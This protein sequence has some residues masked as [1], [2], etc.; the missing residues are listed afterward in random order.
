MKLAR[1]FELFLCV[2]L[3]LAFYGC[4]GSD[5]DPNMDMDMDMDMDGG[6]DS[7]TPFVPPS[8]GE[9]VK[10]EPEGAVCANGSQYKYFVNFAD[11]GEGNASENF[12]FYF[13]PGGACWDYESCTQDREIRGAANTRDCVGEP[14]TVDCLPD[15]HASRWFSIEVPPESVDLAEDFGIV[16]GK[17]PVSLAFPLLSDNATANP[18]HDWNKVWVSYCTGDV[19]SGNKVV[20]YANPDDS[21]RDGRVSPR[22]QQQHEAN[23][24]RTHFKVSFSRKDDGHRV[25]CWRYGRIVQL[26]LS[27]QRS[28]S[29]ARLSIG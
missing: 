16:D 22:G 7:G 13:E 14:S 3:S 17:A 19:H 10:Y 1:L 11:D 5:S 24:R 23:D 29:P 28:Q 18:M 26:L 4:G 21:K 27:A 12:V 6:M 25:Q 8:F 2:T 9:W 15:D 20:T